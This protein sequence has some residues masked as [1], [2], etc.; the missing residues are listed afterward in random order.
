MRRW[1]KMIALQIASHGANAEVAIFEKRHVGPRT[2]TVNPVGM[3]DCNVAL[4][5]IG[6]CARNVS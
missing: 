2:T 1:C 5:L 3:V 6:C 4:G